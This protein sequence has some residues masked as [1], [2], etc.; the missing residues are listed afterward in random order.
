MLFFK[1][2]RLPIFVKRKLNQKLLFMY[3]CYTNIFGLTQADCHC[4]EEGRP[5]GYNLSTSGL[6]LDGLAAISSLNL[7]ECDKTTWD[8]ITQA[9]E[10]AIKEFVVNSNALLAD[11]Y[12]LKRKPVN[13]AVLGQVKALETYTNTKNYAVVRVACAP[14]RGGVWTIKGLGGVF[15]GTQTIPVTIYNNLGE[16]FGTY[17]LT[18]TNG[19]HANT[20]QNIELPLHSKYLK[21]LEYYF[22]YSFNSQSLPKDTEISC[23]CGNVTLTFNTKA[24]YYNDID[25]K[26]AVP[27]TNYVMVG[28]TEINSLTELETLPDKVSNKMYG[29]T[30]ESNFSCKVGE[31]LCEDELDF[32]GNP[33]ALSM[34]LAIRYLAGVKVANK[35][36]SSS[37]LTRENMIDREDW[38]ANAE[39]WKKEYEEHVNYIVNQ[40]SH[41]ANDC[42]ECKD[43]LGMS[44]RGLFA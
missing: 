28:G 15:V 21:Q 7:A 34:A 32:T 19:V 31:V 16:T 5:E 22:V 42:F 14:V 36:L 17:N 23:G 10:E 3:E 41:T 1:G 9:R 35:V 33:L 6:Y 24:P 20:A 26:K 44:R 13:R 11:K 27:W 29:L 30:I 8:I 37:I 38:I 12:T 25:T 4:T 40:A 43:L 18:A 2:L 39:T